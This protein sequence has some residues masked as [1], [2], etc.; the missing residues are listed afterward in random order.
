[1]KVSAAIPNAVSTASV[2]QFSAG[3]GQLLEQEQGGGHGGL[4]VDV[5]GGDGEVEVELEEQLVETGVA[6]AGDVGADLVERAP[7]RAA[8]VA[9]ERLPG[10]SDGA[11]ADDAERPGVPTG[12]GRRRPQLRHQW[13]HP[14]QRDVAA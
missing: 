13:D 5:G 10:E 12:V 9:T 11:P 3:G 6:V 14:G 2:E 1:M 4:G 7:Q 8:V